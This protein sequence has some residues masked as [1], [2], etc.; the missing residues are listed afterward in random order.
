M[1]IT[2]TEAKFVT[3]IWRTI[4]SAIINAK[5]DGKIMTTAIAYCFQ[6]KLS[7]LLAAYPIIGATKPP[8]DAAMTITI[9]VVSSTSAITFHSWA[10]ATWIPAMVIPTTNKIIP[11]SRNFR[12]IELLDLAIYLRIK[13]YWSDVLSFWIMNP[14]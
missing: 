13:T 6:L 4:I 2:T 7:S 9:T 1:K 14:C 8:I 5:V 3:F 10:N 11:V 12:F